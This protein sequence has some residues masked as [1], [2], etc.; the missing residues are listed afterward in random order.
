MKPWWVILIT[1]SACHAARLPPKLNREQQRQ[2][3]TVRFPYRIAVDTHRFVMTYLWDRGQPLAVPRR[4]TIT[5]PASSNGLIRSLRKTQLF[6]EVDYAHRLSGPPDLVAAISRG[7]GGCSVIPVWTAL[8][9]GIIPTVCQ[10]R[11]GVEFTFRAPRTRDSVAVSYVGRG[12]VVLGWIGGVLSAFPGWSRK[13]VRMTSR[14]DDHVAAT[15]T[16]QADAIQ[17][18]AERR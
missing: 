3:E 12:P 17:R 9:L 11:Y 8:T 5:A 4:D 15:I 14:Y 10:E 13:S 18:L 7:I 1:L 6:L 16:A 2:I